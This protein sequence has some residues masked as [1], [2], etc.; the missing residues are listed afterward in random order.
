[1]WSRKDN[2]KAHILRMHKGMGID[3]DQLIMSSEFVPNRGDIE[4]LAR[5]KGGTSDFG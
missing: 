4:F 1:M 2:F 5:K 3:V